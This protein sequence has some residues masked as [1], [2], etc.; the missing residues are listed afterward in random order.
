M[1]FEEALLNA[2]CNADFS[3]GGQIFVK[4]SASHISFTNSGKFNVNID[5]AKKGT[6]SDPRNPLIKKIFDML[7]PI[8]VFMGGIPYIH[9][10][11]Q[12]NGWSPP[13]F[14]QNENTTTLKLYFYNIEFSNDNLPHI[15]ASETIIHYLTEHI[16]ADSE[17]LAKMLNLSGTNIETILEKMQENKIIVSVNK[18]NNLL[19]KLKD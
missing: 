15:I 3:L 16:Y 11:W 19:Y 2:I 6:V 17:E 10:I 13:Y 14:Q 9:M 5:D 18:N 7:K 12:K 4:I 1:C 8:Q